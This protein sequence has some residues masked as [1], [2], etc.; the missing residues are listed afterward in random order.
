[1]EILKYRKDANSPWQD[2]L[3]IK[4]NDGAPG[5][6]GEPGPKGEPGN[7]Y[8]LTNADKNEIAALAL[9]LLPT[10]EGVKY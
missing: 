1:M 5:K 2:I 7:D 4:G 8:V 3:A 9:A 6:D 10:S